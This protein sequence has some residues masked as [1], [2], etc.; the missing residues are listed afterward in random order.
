MTPL[1]PWII[2]ASAIGADRATAPGNR[3]GLGLIGVGM[4]GRGHLQGFLHNTK[5]QVLA[6]CDVDQWRREDA[7]ATTERAYAERRASGSYHGCAAYRDFR[8]LLARGD[9]DAVFIGTGDRWHGVATVMAAEAG[10]DIYVEKPISLTI[11]EA[12]AMVEAVRRYGRVC[13][14]GLQQRSTREFRLACQLVRDGALGK[15]QFVYVIS[16]GTSG[17][18]QLPAEPIPESL[19]WDLWLGPCPWRPFNHRFLYLGRP[20]NVV[21]WDFCRDFGGGALTSGTVH[22]FDVVQWGLNMDHSGP[23]EVVPLDPGP[24]PSLALKYPHGVVCHVVPGRLDRR[25]HAI[26][27]GW[28]EQTPIQ[29]FGALFVGERGWI[30]VGRAGFLQSFPAE[31][32]K[33]HPSTYGPLIAGPDHHDDWFEA[34]L[35]R[36]RPACD[37]AVG[38]QSTIVSHLCCIASWTGR[39]LKWDPVREEFQ[40]DDEANR[41]RSRS[42]REPWR[43]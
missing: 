40:G 34:I 22:A 36:R 17:D 30:H 8:D 6:V 32:I 31:I 25:R 26:P 7:R 37:V 10:K 21:P 16:P 19:D 13:Q 5:A 3:I 4:V 43:V 20:L 38:C 1:A 9:I 42:M 12:R 14:V 33:D 41:L 24:H 27:K 11:A 35:A 2:P 18:V 23:T 39:T 28:D 29:V 15:I